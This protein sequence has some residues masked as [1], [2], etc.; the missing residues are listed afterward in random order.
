[1]TTAH[2]AEH[3]ALPNFVTPTSCTGQ[4]DFNSILSE[5]CQNENTAQCYAEAVKQFDRWFSLRYKG[6]EIR[7]A[8]AGSIQD[9]IDSLHSRHSSS[10]V[11]QHLAAL[12]KYYSW[13]VAEGVIATNPA[14]SVRGP[15]RI[16]D[17]VCNSVLPC[18]VV[19]EL[20]SKQPI[21]GALESRDYAI[22]A[23][24][25]YAFA[26]PSALTKV[27]RGD[28]M[29]DT[30][31]LENRKGMWVEVPLNSRLKDYLS[32]CLEVFGKQFNADDLLFPCDHCSSGKKIAM[33]RFAIW[34]AIRRRAQALELP[35]VVNPRSLR[36]TAISCYLENGGS[37]QVVSRIT[38]VSIH[39]A[40]KY[41]GIEQALTARELERI[42]F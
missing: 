21:R 22:L 25:V 12:R 28:L 17:S 29:K 13:L 18:P 26:T 9:Y 8:H 7:S 4:L 33:S 42:R 23:T 32:N 36:A 6:L 16:E 34:Q 14:S 10:T 37:A 39:G 19:A 15:D 2:L 38:G 27:R 20:L 40:K 1:M 11:K 3:L 41:S 5:E 35:I 31:R 24:I 30:I